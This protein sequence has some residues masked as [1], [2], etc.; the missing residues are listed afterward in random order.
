MAFGTL[1]D[2]TAG[3]ELVIFPDVY[4]QNEAALKSDGALV[5]SGGFEKSDNTDGGRAALKILVEKIQR[6]QD[7][8]KQAK[9]IKI[10]LN[11]EKF[12][13]QE[14]NGKMALLKEAFE[15]NPGPTSCLL[16]IHLPDI[17]QVVDLEVSTP[18]G[19]DLSPQFFE[20]VATILEEP[21]WSLY[22]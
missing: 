15:K 1:E 10:E 9:K 6:V 5:V 13:E 14:L 17:N 19:V 20:R 2:T 4:A 18:R 21:R 3:L 7:L 16:Q 11:V 8:F 22:S 12:G